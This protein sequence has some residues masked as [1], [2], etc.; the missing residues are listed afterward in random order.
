MITIII[1][2]ITTFLKTLDVSASGTSSSSSSSSSSSVSSIL[3]HNNIQ[4]QHPNSDLLSIHSTQSTSSFSHHPLIVSTTPEELNFNNLQQESEP[5]LDSTINI[6]NET[7]ILQRIYRHLNMQY[8][9]S[10][11]DNAKQTKI[12]PILS[13]SID[14]NNNNNNN[15]ETTMF[16]LWE[17]YQQQNQSDLILNPDVLHLKTAIQQQQQQ[18]LQDNILASSKNSLNHSTQK[19]NTDSLYE[20][21]SANVQ[22]LNSRQS[23]TN[24]NMN[25]LIESSNVHFRN[26]SS[27]NNNNH[28]QHHHIHSDSNAVQQ[29][30]SQNNLLHRIGT[31]N[32]P[33]TSNLGNYLHDRSS[34]LF[35]SNL[36]LSSHQHFQSNSDSHSQIKLAAQA[37][38][39][40]MAVRNSTAETAINPEM[41]DLEKMS[42]SILNHYNASVL[43]PSLLNNFPERK[44]NS[45]N[46]IF[47]NNNS[48]HHHHQNFTESPIDQQETNKE[49]SL[50]MNQLQK[51]DKSND[52]TMIKKSK[53]KD[54][55]TFSTNNRFISKHCS[56]KKNN[57]YPEQNNIVETN[58]VPESIVI[59]RMNNNKNRS[60]SSK[61]SSTENRNNVEVPF[62]PRN[63]HER[64]HI[65]RPM[66]AFMV[67]AKDERRKILKACPDMHN[68]NISKILGARW[69]AMTSVE[70][71]PFYE[72]QS[73][74]S[75]VHMQQHPDYRYRPRP[76]RTCIVDGKKLRISE[77]KQLMRSRRQEM[78]TLWY[79]DGIPVNQ[80][81]MTNSSNDLDS[82]LTTS[83]NE[84]TTKTDISMTS[85]SSSSSSSLSSPISSISSPTSSSPLINSPKSRNNSVIIDFNHS[86]T[87][88]ASNPRYKKHYKHHQQRMIIKSPQQHA[89]KDD[90][91]EDDFDNDDEDLIE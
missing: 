9:N 58:V 86:T 76:K 77:Y 18:Y 84:L 85:P 14:H 1:I 42:H 39:A 3:D 44:S 56:D 20:S 71:Q 16:Q 63:P 68:S 53:L 27:N 34:N 48:N 79:R 41:F 60:G 75:R 13:P 25:R 83:N 15:N 78:R 87:N 89:S 43:M 22:T 65:K 21:L 49:S 46:E 23:P 35:L 7:D 82:C 91:S 50:L 28:H 17:K 47:N 72:E 37:A 90:V 55:S 24:T 30:L 33:T 81:I 10:N 51:S 5:L 4:S 80:N 59:T 26:T 19:T 64:G 40:A 38:A 6:S 8:L 67:W 2:I 54:S 88:M 57:C 11:K 62:M 61:K 69:K 73:R 45:K 29:Y 70:K 52:K 31:D 32:P 12:K 74:L 36:L 66:N